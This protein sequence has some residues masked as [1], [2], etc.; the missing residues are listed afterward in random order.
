[1][2]GMILTEAAPAP[3]SCAVPT[4]AESIQYV[5]PALQKT[6]VPNVTGLVPAAT[7]AVN[8]RATPDA[9]EEAERVRVVTVGVNA[10]ANSGL[11]RRM[12][13]ATNQKGAFHIRQCLS[14]P[15]I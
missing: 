7:A 2:P 14:V 6:M 9:C 5:A 4:T 11:H 10:T 1:M 15:L 3:V 12:N 13:P 8:V